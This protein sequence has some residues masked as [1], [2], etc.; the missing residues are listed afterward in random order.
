MSLCVYIWDFFFFS[1]FLL[2]E[3]HG[4]HEAIWIKKKNILY[5]WETCDKRENKQILFD[6]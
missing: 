4:D 6:V 2:E 1:F 5:E 3:T